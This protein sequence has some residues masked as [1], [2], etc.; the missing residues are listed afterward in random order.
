MRKRKEQ[1]KLVVEIESDR[2]TGRIKTVSVFDNRTQKYWSVDQIQERGIV[3]F[4]NLTDMKET[5]NWNLNGDRAKY[6]F[7]WG[8]SCK[9]RSSGV[10]YIYH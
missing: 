8:Q 10:A 2:K 1:P 6:Q 3:W 5:L 9:K 7:K 4:L